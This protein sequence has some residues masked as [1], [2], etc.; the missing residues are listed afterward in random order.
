[1]KDNEVSKVIYEGFLL[2][3]LAEGKFVAA[4]DPYVV[5]KGLE[6]VQEAFEVQKKGVSVKKIAVPL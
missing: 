4:P 2:K 5:G 6:C 3:A 1:M